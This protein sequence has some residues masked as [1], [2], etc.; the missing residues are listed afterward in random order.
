MHEDEAK[1]AHEEH[2]E[3]LV[4]AREKAGPPT[5]EAPPVSDKGTGQNKFSKLG[6]DLGNSWL[7][8]HKNRYTYHANREAFF[9]TNFSTRAESDI[10]QGVQ[11]GFIGTVSILSFILS[12]KILCLVQ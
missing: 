6:R 12:L 4:E 5:Y 8:S 1:Q 9:D 10:R 11:N 3:A 7:N 2:H